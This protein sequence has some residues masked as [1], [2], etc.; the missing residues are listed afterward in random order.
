LYLDFWHCNSTG[1][2]AGVVANGNGD[3]SDPTNINA[4]FHRGLAPTDKDG[5]VQFTTKF[6]G[7]YTGRAVHIHILGNH[8]GEV[9]S[10]NTYIGSTSSNVG[11]LFFDQDL[12]TQVVATGTYATSKQQLTLN[13]NDGIFREEAATGFDPVME[14][15]FVGEEIDDGIF[16][17]ISVGIKASESKYVSPAVLWT[18][19]GGVPVSGGGGGPP[20]GPGNNGT[21]PPGGPPGNGTQ[22]PRC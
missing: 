5:I 17:W 3:S 2:Y 15:V 11:Q 20:G 12:I 8:G 21:F 13:A 22:R 16:A 6:P 10:N 7:Y 14:Y 19:G 4:T 9:A 18:A 1:V